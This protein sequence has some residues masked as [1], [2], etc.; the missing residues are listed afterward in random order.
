M[1]T[2]ISLKYLNISKKRIS[3]FID[4]KIIK[5]HWKYSNKQ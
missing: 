1:N 3:N 5:T 2:F 4:L